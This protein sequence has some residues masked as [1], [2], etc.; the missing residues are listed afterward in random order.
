MKAA[1]GWAVAD[2]IGGDWHIDLTT[3]A[4]TRAQAIALYDKWTNAISERYRA[5]HTYARR[6]RRGDARALRVEVQPVPPA[7]AYIPK[8]VW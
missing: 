8:E 2:L 6:R 7:P 3:V 5:R 4:R 1:T